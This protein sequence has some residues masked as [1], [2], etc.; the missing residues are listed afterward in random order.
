V[1]RF[2]QACSVLSLLVLSGCRNLERFDTKSGVAYCGSMVS[3]GFV[4][5]GLLPK[6]VRPS[7]N[8]RLTL[9]TSQLAAL[10]GRV[11][12]D[13]TVRGLCAPAPLFQDAPLRSIEQ[14]A[15]DDLSLLEFGSGRELNFLA[16]VD[17]SCTQTMLAVVSLMRDDSVEL[18]LLKPAPESGSPELAHA[19][20]GFGI[21]R[22]HQQQGDCGF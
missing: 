11:S 2:L 15:N 18:R 9:D 6:N 10:P 16:W 19:E 1:K 20:P 13:D 4:R 21:F 12:T 3:A 5:G 17:S 7:L 14:V 22:L 8:M